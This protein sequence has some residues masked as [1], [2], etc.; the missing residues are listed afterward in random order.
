MTSLS[1]LKT[2]LHFSPLLGSVVPPRWVLFLGALLSGL[3]FSYERMRAL[4]NFV[5]SKS[6]YRTL[7]MFL[8]LRMDIE[9]KEDLEP[10]GVRVISRD[11]RAIGVPN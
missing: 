9:G 3:A 5:T 8:N 7:L 11:A 2:T 10:D 1:Y 4:V 6:G